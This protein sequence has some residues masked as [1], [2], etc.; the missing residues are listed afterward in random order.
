MKGIKFKRATADKKSQQVDA[1]ENNNLI[2]NSQ[3]DTANGKEKSKLSKL[4]SKITKN[5]TSKNSVAHVEKAQKASFFSFLLKGLSNVVNVKKSLGM[6]IFI[7]FIVSLIACVATVGILSYSIAKSKLE[8]NIIVASKE[9]IRQ[10]SRNIDTT[11]K[12][13]DDLTFQFMFDE[14]ITSNISTYIAAED[15]IAQIEANRTINDL[16][17]TYIFSNNTIRNIA[18]IP[19]KAATDPIVN[20]AITSNMANRSSTTEY[21]AMPWFQQVV[22]KNG[23]VVWISPQADGIVEGGI[24]NTVAL[25]RIVTNTT[26]GNEYVLVIEFLTQDLFSAATDVSIIENSYLEIIDSTN[27]YVLSNQPEQ[28]GLDANFDLANEIAESTLVNG[29]FTTKHKEN[30]DDFI[31]VY[32]QIER[33]QSWYLSG[34]LPN[35]EIQKEARTIFSFTLLMVIVAFA[36]AI[37]IGFIMLRMVS[38]PLTQISTVMTRGAKGDLTVRAPIMNRSDEIGVLAKTFDDMMI[39]IEALAREATQSASHVLTTATELTQASNKTATAGKEISIA[40]DEIAAGASS[41][42]VEAEKGSDLTNS[43]TEQM[44]QVNHSREQMITSASQVDEASEQGLTYM[45]GL[46]ERTGE[47]EQMVKEMVNKVNA[48]SDSTKSIVKILDVLNNITK[49][50][51]IL[52]LNA[53]IEAARAGQAGKGFMVVAD[54]I[55]QLAEQSRQSIDVVGQITETISNEIV[56]TVQVLQQ[57]Q[58]IFQ[59]QIVSV[60]EAN[61]I[62]ISVRSQMDLLK[63]NINEVSVAFDNLS[64]SQETLSQSMNNVSAVA[65]Q[66]SATSEEVASLSS[67]QLVI[68]EQLVNLSSQLE[69]VSS[70]LKTQLSKF[71]IGN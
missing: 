35:D 7:V 60:K 48:L 52:S 67:E 49:Q 15:M 53:T 20:G 54:E 61:Q 29:S 42:A 39:Q 25:G 5:N 2:P 11:L 19:A 62:F 57:A 68:S 51:N 33:N 30:N 28:V 66:S 46:I 58:P 36:L 50:T 56:D 21:Q 4:I 64:T 24:N 44:V 38:R 10:V 31:I 71:K 65:Q 16:L 14:K 55:R 26:K 69:A 32:S 1:I 6:K 22:E 63:E 18:L 23:S 59:E 70:N 17:S 41:L 9:T 40:T 8:D 37:V 47:T 45:N 12:N 13:I 34:A 3:D 27:K 43:I